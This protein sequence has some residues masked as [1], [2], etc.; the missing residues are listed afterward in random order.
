MDSRGQL[1]LIDFAN[2]SE[3]RLVPP[4]S[5][6]HKAPPSSPGSSQVQGHLVSGKYYILMDIRF[7][8]RQWREELSS[9]DDANGWFCGHAEY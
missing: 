6:S 7:R 3:I 8:E 4:V 9:F 2:G 1:R 5:L